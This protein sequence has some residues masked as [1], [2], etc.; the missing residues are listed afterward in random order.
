MSTELVNETS[1]ITAY[2]TGLLHEKA[3]KFTYLKGTKGGI[4]QQSIAAS[5]RTRDIGQ[6]QH[7][8]PQLFSVK[9]WP[10]QNAFHGHQGI[11]D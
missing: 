8:S 6:A 2:L 1:A 4:L 9:G 10:G 5:D 3:G 11:Y 7:H